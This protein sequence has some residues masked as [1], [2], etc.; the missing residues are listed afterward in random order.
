MVADALAAGQ[1]KA[2]AK[3]LLKGA[4]WAADR[5]IAAIEKR[6]AETLRRAVAAIADLEVQTR[7]GELSED[8][9]AIRAVLIATR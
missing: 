4:P 6:D 8:T 5:T 7:G 2:Q 9:E 3:K 1:S